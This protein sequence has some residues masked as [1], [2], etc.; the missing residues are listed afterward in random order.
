MKLSDYAKNLGISYRTAWRYFKQ[1]KLDAYQTHTGTIIIKKDI[2]K[3]NMLKVAIYC[4]VSSSEN[5]DNL[6]RQKQR[7]LNYCSAKGYR[8]NKVIT[9]IGSGI[10]DTRKQWLS[11][12]K[13]KQINLIVIEYKDRF[14]R[15][16]FSA[17]ELL[18]ENEN[19]KIEVIN[20]TEDGK[21]DL[22]QDFI[23]IITSFCA[24][25]YGLS[26]SKEKLKKII[27]E[28]KDEKKS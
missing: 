8:V 16:G 17:M 7:L 26:R 20:E 21:E 12:L 2:E 11:L 10:N 14:T 6:E 25:I 13:D 24:R 3:N 27:K 9:E 28:L 15:F 4:R 18:L 22:M 5:R 19:R 1:G 23:S